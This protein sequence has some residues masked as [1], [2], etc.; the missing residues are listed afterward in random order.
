VQFLLKAPERPV[1]SERTIQR[2]FVRAD[3]SQVR[4]D[5]P[6]ARAVPMKG[7]IE[8]WAS[9]SL[10]AARQAYP[11]PET[12]NRLKSGQK[13]GDA[14]VEANL[15]VARQRLHLGGRTARDGA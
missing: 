2:W 9:E 3:L 12:G 11:V 1:P 15:P 5:S 4:L 8:D 7:S 10:L 13:L 14:Y 6:E